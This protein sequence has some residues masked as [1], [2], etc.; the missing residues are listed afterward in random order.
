MNYRE[1][2]EFWLNNVKDKKMLEELKSMNENEIQLAF[3]KDIAFETAGLRGIVGAGSNCMNIYTVGR[4]AKA[5]SIYMQ[6]IGGKKIAISYD[7]RNMSYEFAKLSARIFA[8]YGIKVY[9]AN[10]LMPT[11]F[12][13]YMV[14]F[15]KCDMGVNVTASHNPK[16]YNGY[17]VYDSTGCQLLDEP[18]YE[19][20]NIANGLELFNISAMSFNKAK[21]TGLVVL[22][23]DKV[24]DSYIKEVEKQSL[25]KIEGIKV[26][27]TALN[28]TGMGTLPRVLKERGA[29]VVCNKVQCKPDKNF[30][31]CP[32][33][34]PERDDVYESSIAIAKENGIDLIVASD[35]DADRLGVAQL[36]QGNFVRFTG[37]EIGVLLAD[38]L[39]SSKKTKDK[40]LVKSIVS[41]PL[42]D[43]VAE[44]YGGK[45]VNVL[46]GFKYIGEFIY[47]LEKEG[48]EKEFLLGFEE[49]SGYLSGS[50]V[51]DKDATVAAML[52][53]EYASKLKKVGKTLFDRLNEIYD[54][55]G[56]YQSK[57]Y[58]FRFEG[59]SGFNRMKEILGNF[60]KNTPKSFAGFKVNSVLDYENGVRDLPKANVLEYILDGG[61]K[62]IV[63]PSGTEPNIKVYVMLNKTKQQNETDFNL[64]K[65]EFD[66]IMK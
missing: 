45:V 63:R 17:K 49:S 35:P 33:P 42:A 28:G 60:R 3:F 34:N 4:V 66:K 38:Y 54:E 64:I 47:K 2:Y 55:F 11:P 30:T 23:D 5:I 15:Y 29:K 57:V 37:N 14:R 16:D 19:I 6:K 13:S 65:K 12:L 27:Y 61:A 44:K 25:Q 18:S 24:L 46:T 43:L 21:E 9:L 40:I 58:S 8:S 53:L 51:R 41:T 22:T 31:T 52:I 7:S 56:Y 36:V 32:Y 20:I 10:K 1:K 59:E 50:Y 62:I 48:R 26:V 39:F